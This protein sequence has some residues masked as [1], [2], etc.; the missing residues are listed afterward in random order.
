[1]SLRLRNPLGLLAWTVALLPPLSRAGTADW[2]LGASAAFVGAAVVWTHAAPWETRAPARRAGRFFFGMTLLGVL[3]WAYSAAFNGLQTGLLDA[4]ELLRP[5]ALGVVAVHIVRHRDARLADDVD[6]ALP[7]ALY[8]QPFYARGPEYPWTASLTLAWALFF[9]R[10]RLR[11]LH[12]AAAALLLVLLGGKGAWAAGALTLGAATAARLLKDQLAGHPGK[13]APLT[14]LCLA[15]LAA[16]P[17]LGVRSAMSPAAD[18]PRAEA[19]AES[20]RAVR[21][22]PVFGWGPGMYERV[23]AADDQYLAWAARGGLLGL[24]WVFGGIAVLAWSLLWGAEDAARKLGLAAL[25]GSAALLLLS[26]RFLDG[27]RLELL[28]GLVAGAASTTGERA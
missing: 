4:L 21:R 14:V 18:E 13:V 17:V 9:S 12:A 8:L 2:A 26:G 25:V 23:A 27:F 11:L 5:V 15:L 6:L 22:S 24:C 1:M 19:A 10:S 16:A 20:W 3:S 7:A 28:T